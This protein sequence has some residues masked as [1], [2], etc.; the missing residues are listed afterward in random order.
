MFQLRSIE[1]R[2]K[3]IK[4]MAIGNISKLHWR[5]TQVI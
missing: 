1:M 4:Q 3:T 2:K 5:A